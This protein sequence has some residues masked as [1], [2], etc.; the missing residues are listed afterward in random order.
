MTEI[1]PPVARL[2]DFRDRV[3]LVTGASGGIGAGVAR[4]F[5]EA[6]AA[7]VVHYRS[8]RA[9]AERV[10]AGIGARALAVHADLTVDAELEAM[11]DAAMARFGRIDALINNA[12]RQTH[13]PLLE[14]P[15]AEFDAMMAANLGGA[16]R[17]TQAV[18]RRMR[19]QGG[20]AIVNIAS[21]SG[22][23][24]AFTHAHYCTS[25]AGLLMFTRA[26]ALEL[27]P[28]GIR[29]NAVA[30]G[31]IWREGLDQAWPEGVARWL[32][33]APLGRVGRDDD[34]AD[35]CLFLCSPAA[36]F[37]TGAVL[38]VDGGVTAHPSY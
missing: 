11:V 17:C 36:R 32:A 10:V 30:P 24:P 12:A 28:L 2:L 38:T 35:A 8:D 14:M 22:L 18:A 1:A 15:T 9:G 6:G 20:G 3:V 7:V 34:V 13:A 4:R 31:L 37:V 19:A 27:G 26:A 21:I 5:G 33:H 29:V 25:K 16:F 23:E